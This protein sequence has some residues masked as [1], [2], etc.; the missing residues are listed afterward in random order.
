MSK[1]LKSVFGVKL[2]A[3]IIGKWAGTN[4]QWANCFNVW[5]RCVLRYNLETENMIFRFAH[6]TFMK[7]D[8]QNNNISI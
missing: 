5:L 6:E 1:V 3:V 8:W 7:S 4:I 2:F